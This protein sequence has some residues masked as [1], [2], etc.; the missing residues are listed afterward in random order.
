MSNTN[1]ESEN[2]EKSED[3]EIKSG[4]FDDVTFE[5][6]CKLAGENP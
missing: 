3:L 6:K 1:G 2:D 5:H 4:L